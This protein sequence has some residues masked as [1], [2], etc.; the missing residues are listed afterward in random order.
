M[1]QASRSEYNPRGAL[2]FTAPPVRNGDVAPSILASMRQL[3][4][5]KQTLAVVRGDLHGTRPRLSASP[6]T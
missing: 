5:G 2:F 4:A 6:T 3:G 1:P